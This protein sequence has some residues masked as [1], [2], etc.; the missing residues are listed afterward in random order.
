MNIRP[1][2]SLTAVLMISATLTWGQ[3]GH[4]GGSAPSP[5]APGRVTT[6]R[7]SAT[8]AA[9]PRYANSLVP[10]GWGLAPGPA[11]TVNHPGGI[12]MQP[13]PGFQPLIPTGSS[14]F[15][16]PRRWRDR[17]SQVVVVPMAVYP[18]P[19]GAVIGGYGAA[20]YVDPG[21]DPNAAA[22]PDS[23]AGQQYP[24]D[25]A[26]YAQ[27]APPPVYSEQLPPPDNQAPSYPPTAAPATPANGANDSG[28]ADVS[29]TLLAFK[30]H[31]FFAVTDYWVENN[32]LSYITNYGTTG[33][34]ALDRLDLTLTVKL[35]NERGV[36][37]E[38]HEK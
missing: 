26:M 8:T 16:S 6:P 37:F 31:S 36:T 25:P 9:P 21:V 5:P 12:P 23:S 17:G 15:N 22:G 27:S 3:H 32:R 2:I 33:T 20:N 29:Y 19:A 18:M 7:F 13:L 11:S 35:N 34:A 4:A 10:P 14:A 30:D 38:L 24:P 1:A 28:A